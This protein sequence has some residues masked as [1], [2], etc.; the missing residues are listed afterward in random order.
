MKSKII[1]TILLTLIYILGCSKA[2]SVYTNK[3][4]YLFVL[5]IGM[6]IVLGV[7]IG[8]LLGNRKIIKI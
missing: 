5:Y 1:T 3:E 2:L 6:S 7:V 8:L 4:F